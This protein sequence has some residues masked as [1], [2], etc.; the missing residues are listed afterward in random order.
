LSP[1]VLEV[2][3][4]DHG[5]FVPGPAAASVAVLGRVVAAMEEFLDVLAD[6][7]T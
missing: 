2:E 7:S 3:G 4:A 6:G 1:H 5:M